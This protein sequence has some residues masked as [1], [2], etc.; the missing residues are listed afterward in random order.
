MARKAEGY[1][2]T[3]K[4]YTDDSQTHYYDTVEEKFYSEYRVN[5]TPMIEMYNKI[6]KATS[7]WHYAMLAKHKDRAWYIRV[8]PEIKVSNDKKTL[9]VYARYQFADK[10]I[11]HAVEG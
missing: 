5:A 7:R 11:V 9:M 10:N 6:R 1:T 8:L 2:K 3:S 4:V